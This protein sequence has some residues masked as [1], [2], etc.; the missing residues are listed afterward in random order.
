MQRNKFN[1]FNKRGG[2]IPALSVLNERQKMDNKI[3]KIREL[4]DNL[5]QNFSGGKVMVTRGIAGFNTD[6]THLFLP[7][8][9]GVNLLSH[10]QT[11][12][13]FFCHQEQ[14]FAGR[15]AFP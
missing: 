13:Y 7:F 6:N 8:N 15:F 4:N 5:R 10:I 1:K 3:K 9:K 14:T 12:F 11:I 2:K